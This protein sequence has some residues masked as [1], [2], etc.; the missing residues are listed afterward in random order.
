M[1]ARNPRMQ[2]NGKAWLACYAA[3]FVAEFTREREHAPAF[4]ENLD[5]ALGLASSHA[6]AARFIAD[7]AVAHMKEK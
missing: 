2:R 7:A 1:A 5:Y 3:A 6:E 4:S